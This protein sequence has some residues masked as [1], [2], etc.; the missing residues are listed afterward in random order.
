VLGGLISR[1]LSDTYARLD[2]LALSRHRRARGVGSALI[3]EFLER[4]RAE[5]VEVVS[6]GFFRPAFFANFGFGVD[7]R[8]AGLVCFLD[9]SAAEP[10]RVKRGPEESERER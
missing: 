5:G 2:W 7:P 1:R 8:Y 3:R 9:T 4:Q 6:T 10:A